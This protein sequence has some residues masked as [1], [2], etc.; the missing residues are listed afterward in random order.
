MT[1]ATRMPASM[2]SSSAS[3]ATAGGAKM[4]ETSAPVAS[5]ASATLLKTGRSR[6]V[7]PPLPGVTPATTFVRVAIA[8]WA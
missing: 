1:T 6:C 7:D 2:A 4:P 8:S 5:T 3:T